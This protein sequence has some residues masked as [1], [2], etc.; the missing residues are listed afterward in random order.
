MKKYIIVLTFVLILILSGCQKSER[1]VSF[2]VDSGYRI[3]QYEGETIIDLGDIKAYD[4]N[5][6]DIT[7]FISITGE[8]DLDVPGEY[9]LT[10]TVS[11]DIGT[12]GS[13][14]ITLAIFEIT[15]AIDNTQDKCTVHVDSLEFTESTNSIT[16]VFIDDFVKFN[17]NLLPTTAANQEVLISSSDETI[18]TVSEYGY[19]FAHA[20]G[21]VT[22][23][24]TATDGDISIS[25]VINV[26]EKTCDDD[27][28]QDKCAVDILGDD[29]RII[30]LA[31]ANL[32]GIDYTTIHV[33]NKIYYQIYVRTFADSDGNYKGDF[34][35][36]VDN[37]QYLKDLGIG[38]IW[39][40]PI[41]ESRSDHGYEV[42]DYYDVDSEYGT[43]IDFEE[44]LSV[45]EA[46]GIDIIID[47]VVNH[48]GARNEI[49]QDVLKN[50]VTSDYYDWFSWLDSSDSRSEYGGSWGQTIWYNPTNRDWLKGSTFTIHS[51][52]DDKVYC[53]YFSDWM[54]DFNL[55]NPEVR[56]YLKDV[57]EFW[58]DKGV[59]GFRMDATSHFYGLNE[60]FDLNNHEENI[61]FL[62][63]YNDFL[64]TVNPDV[65]VVVEAWESYQTY[66]EYYSTG[67]SAFNFQANYDIRDVV[68]GRLSDDIGDALNKV[69]NYIDNYDADFIDAV[70][71]SN[72]DSIGRIAGNTSSFE[73]TR[74][75]AEILLTLPGNPYIYYGDEVGMLGGRTNMIWGDYY[76]GLTIRYE[77]LDIDTVATQLVD[78]ASLLNRYIDLGTVRNNSLA[79][80]Y[81]SFTPYSS[82]NLEGYYRVFENGDDKELVIVL[83]NFT[84]TYYVPIPDEFSNYEILYNTFDSNLGGISPNSTVILRLPW[85]IKDDLI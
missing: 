20:I 29:S 67:V 74:Q 50:G 1:P 80:S 53:A 28:L 42:D 4:F 75:A 43:M 51:S 41:N 55:E 38:G 56:Q 71:L 15:C 5:Q 52:L 77:D 32:S 68:N 39:L 70:F 60:H 3:T 13:I 72:H 66:A 82:S 9:P 17:Y 84:S 59:D 7:S 78:E 19:V 58:L 54:P 76:A 36:I 33:N 6:K 23:T 81:G 69:Y 40:M 27:P 46:M 47:L 65:Y 22:I 63:E 24:F 11:D 79:L 16:E 37:L 44:L 18:A 45:S 25:K 62:T 73:D 61:D 48:M 10:L 30:T 2:S 21:E 85:D 57:A 35:G 83:F 64:L 12:T 34:G 8:H 26:I 49:F 14:T 31:E